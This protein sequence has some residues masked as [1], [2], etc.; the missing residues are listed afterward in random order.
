MYCATYW[1]LL[2]SF[3]NKASVN[4]FIY[5]FEFSRRQLL[6]FR[7]WILFLQLREQ[8]FLVFHPCWDCIPGTSYFSATRLFDI[9]FSRS[10]KALHFL[11]IFLLLCFSSKGTIVFSIMILKYN[12]HWIF[13]KTMNKNIPFFTSLHS[14]LQAQLQQLNKFANTSWEKLIWEE[15]SQ[16]VL[17]IL[18]T[19]RDNERKLLKGMENLFIEDKSLRYQGFRYRESCFDRVLNGQGIG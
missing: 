2:A 9:P 1:Y 4:S 18:G 3:T 17:E 8:R 13:S 6:S 12:L 7:A 10:F 19:V 15:K 5:L 16:K 11:T 14:F